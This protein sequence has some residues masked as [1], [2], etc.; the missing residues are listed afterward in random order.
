MRDVTVPVPLSIDEKRDGPKSPMCWG[1]TWPSQYHSVLMRDVTVPMPQCVDERRHYSSTTMCLWETW[2][3]QCLTVL[4]NCDTEY[5]RASI[6]AVP[7]SRCICMLMYPGPTPQCVGKRRIFVS[8]SQCVGGGVG[9][10]GAYIC[11]N[12]LVF[13]WGTSSCPSV[14]VTY[15]CLSVPMCYGWWT[16]LCP[17]AQVC[18]SGT[19]LCFN[20]SV[21]VCV[22]GWG[23][24]RGA[25]EA[26]LFPTAC[27]LVWDSHLSQCPSVFVTDIPL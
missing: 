14:F 20:V 4:V 18:W 2:L 23:V 27:V 19:Y 21:C 11:L 1:E 17:T 3:C 16:Y 22:G 26:Y 24:G 25:G 12:V 13:W 7:L 10:E 8:V 5:Q 9:G 15:L 6:K